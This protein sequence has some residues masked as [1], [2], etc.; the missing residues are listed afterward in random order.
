MVQREAG[1]G[2]CVVGRDGC[3]WWRE[4]GGSEGGGEGFVWAGRESRAFVE[5]RESRAGRFGRVVVMAGGGGSHLL[6]LWCRVWREKGGFGVLE[7]EAWVRGK[8]KKVSG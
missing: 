1:E 3:L 2:G 5:G 6:W 4:H 7:R 8:E